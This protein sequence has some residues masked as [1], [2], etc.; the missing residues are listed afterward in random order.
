MVVP[1]IMD[2]L[3]DDCEQ[4]SLDAESWREANDLRWYLSQEAGH[5]VGEAAIRKWVLDHWPGFLRQRWL[6]HMMGKCFWFELGREEFGLL[7]RDIG[8][9]TELVDHMLEKMLCGA[10][11]LYFVCWARTQP[12]AVRKMVYKFLELVKI[13]DHRFRCKFSDS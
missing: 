6:D 12:P 3:P 2:P 7:K 4:R 5:D 9:P 8:L 13:N 10:E 11:N 1:V